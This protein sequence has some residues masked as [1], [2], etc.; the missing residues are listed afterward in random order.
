[1]KC[2]HY[3][4]VTALAR[5]KSKSESKLYTT[6]QLW[7]N[8]AISQ[9][10]ESGPV[11]LPCA[12]DARR[13][14]NPLHWHIFTRREWA[15]GRARAHWLID[16]EPGVHSCQTT[17]NNSTGTSQYCPLLL[18]WNS[19]QMICQMATAGCEW[20]EGFFLPVLCG[21]QRNNSS[22]QELVSPLIFFEDH[23]LS[24]RAQ[25]LTCN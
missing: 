5:S 23:A 24:S 21:T 9:R 11:M 12:L 4:L 3:L 6:W 14:M 8:L 19:Y 25:I 17:T 18:M 7:T 1:M 13:S 15:G 22:S 2:R 20:C 10:M 16:A